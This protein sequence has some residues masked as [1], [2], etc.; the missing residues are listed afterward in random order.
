VEVRWIG[1]KVQEFS[2][3]DVNKRH[4]IHEAE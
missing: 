2:G 3:L 1:N 4:E